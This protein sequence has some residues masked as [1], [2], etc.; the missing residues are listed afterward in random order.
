MTIEPFSKEALSDISNLLT[1]LHKALVDQQFRMYEKAQGRIQHNGEKL[2]LLLSHQDFQWLR[3]LS[4]IIA[5]FDD[6]IAEKEMDS[7]QI[8]HYLKEM[9]VL[10]FSNQNKSFSLSYQPYEAQT[11]DVI[12]LHQALKK[13]ITEISKSHLDS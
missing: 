12:L 1:H 4:T 7:T 8:K 9:E 13:S 6:Q 5:S 11:P 3:P 2:Q 10:L